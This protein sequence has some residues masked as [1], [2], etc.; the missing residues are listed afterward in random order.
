MKVRT[1]LTIGFSLVVVLIWITVFF[2][3]NTY[4]NIH[5]E[6]TALEEDIVPG[7]IAMSEMKEKAEEIKAWSFVYMIRGDAVRMGKPVK[8]WLQQNMRSLEKL[9]QEHTEYETH[10]GLEEQKAAE[11]LENRVKQLSSAVVEIISLK[12]QGMVTCPD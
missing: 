3:V 9:A 11:E 12:D 6:F 1:K 7:A 8:E 2:A 4:Q 5:E 10:I